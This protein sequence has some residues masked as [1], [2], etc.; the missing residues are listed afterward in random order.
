MPITV[1]LPDG[2]EIEVDTDDPQTAARAA[3][4]FQ[5]RNPAPGGRAAPRPQAPPTRGQRR[6]VMQEAEQGL[7]AVNR[8]IPFAQD[9][10][11]LTAGLTSAV[12][13]D[14]F[15]Q[16]Y[17]GQR[18]RNTD[19]QTDL[20]A[21]R[22]NAARFLEGTGNALPVALTMGA[23]APQ[24]VAQSSLRGIPLWGRQSALAAAT[25]AASGA[26]YGGATGD[27]GNSDDLM[28]RLQG[29]QEGAGTGA[30]F[31]AAT[32]TAINAARPLINN[33]ARPAWEALAGGARRIPVPA[34]DSVGAMWR[35]MRSAEPRP[36]GPTSPVSG[37]T[38]RRLPRLADRARTT[39]DDVERAIG[40]ARRNPQGQ[41]LVDV[42]ED[43]GVRQLRPIVQSPGRT[44]QIAADAL[45]QRAQA[46]PEI[47]V[48]SLRRNLNVAET[49]SA[50]LRRLEGE[51]R[52]VGA[53]LY[54]PLW[55]RPLAPA[56]RA[57]VE[58]VFRRYHNDPVM[59]DAMRR[60]ERIFA[61]DQANGAA[62]GNI[63]GSFARYAHYVKM[64]L[65]DAVAQGMRRADGS[66]A[67]ASELRGI[68]DM[69]TQ[70][71]RAI[72]DNIPGYQQ[73][74]ARWGGIAEAEEA[75]DEGALFL[76]MDA[77]EV[78]YRMQQMTPFQQEH[79]RIGLAHDLQQRIGLAGNTEG[80]VNVANI[81]ALRA[82]EMQRR[83]AAV[84][85]T[86]EQAAD[87]LGT[88]RTQNRL[89]RNASQWGSGSQTQG[90]QAY[91]AEGIVQ[92]LA[93]TAGDTLS[94]NAGRAFSRTGRQ[95]G[96]LVTNNAV[97]RSNNAFGADLLRRIDDPEAR[98]FTNDLIRILREREAAIYTNN[99]A[100]QIGATGVGSTQGQRR[101]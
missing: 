96:N 68:R 52:T 53:E 36:P 84:F 72:D 15:Q 13:G 14:G 4:A 30:A 17:R 76:K 7:A 10:S 26:P 58:G 28:A 20:S 82:P 61:R 67:G 60:A 62:A 6:S 55:E 99:R 48:E 9:V 75:L 33:V 3:H 35:P 69:R 88:A 51:Y 79:A 56:Q 83:L 41:R 8:G 46:S 66:G 34:G 71:L 98:T 77:E 64:G 44:G 81:Q 86:P 16:G 92:A 97:E 24:V 38:Q 90:N 39:A 19:L 49:R 89:M 73:A 87:F 5:T 18:Q 74:R 100:S 23:A 91:E 50:A 31:G 27:L 101:N 85:E 1:E 95:L 40:D 57:G 2:R 29:A 45:E 12:Q 80:A 25:G 21:R 22:P 65:D 42:F 43:A 47:V 54:N 37:A 32:P 94:G 63:D 70:I 59:Q 78:A 11:A 93:D